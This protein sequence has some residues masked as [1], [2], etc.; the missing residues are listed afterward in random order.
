MYE[1]ATQFYH[2]LSDKFKHEVATYI[3]KTSK[4]QAT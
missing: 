1:K 2:T 3:L 4:F